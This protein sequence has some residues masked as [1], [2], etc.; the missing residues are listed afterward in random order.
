VLGEGVLAAYDGM[1]VEELEARSDA[2]LRSTQHPTLGR[3]YLQCAYA[4]MVELL[5]YLEANGF[6]NSIAP[7]YLDD[8]PQEADPHLF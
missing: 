4:P 6:S 2:F 7:E 1:S 8:G 3:G 5:G